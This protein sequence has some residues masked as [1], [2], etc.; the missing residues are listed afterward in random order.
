MS[1]DGQLMPVD[2]FAPVNLSRAKTST[3]LDGVSLRRADELRELLTSAAHAYYVMDTP[4]LSDGVY[5]AYFRD[6]QALEERFP[7]LKYPDSPTQKVMGAVGEGFQEV[8]HTVP[9]LS[10]YTETDHTPAGAMEFHRRITKALGL[11]EEDPVEYVAEMKFDGLAISLRYEHGRL[12]RAVTRGDGESGEDV[13]Q[14]VMTIKDIPKH[15][16][17]VMGRQFPVLEVRGEIFMKKA[18][19]AAINE[20]LDSVGEKRL[21][22]PRNAAAGALRQH[23]PKVTAQRPLSFFAYGIGEV[24]G[25]TGQP[26]Y[27]QMMLVLS[28]LGFPVNELSMMPIPSSGLL[29]AYNHIQ[30]HREGLPYEIDGVV[31][32]VN[33]RALQEKLGFVSREPRWACAHK[34]P[35]EEA[36]TK[37]TTIEVQVGR[38]GV[39]TPVAVLEPIFVGGTTVTYATLHNETEIRRKDIRIGDDVIVRRAGDVV[40]EI[41]GPVIFARDKYAATSLQ[42]DLFTYVNGV[43]PSCKGPILR[44]DGAVAYRCTSGLACPAQREQGILHFAGRRMMDIQGLGDK[45]VEDLVKTGLVERPSDL[46][47]LQLTDLL[48]LETVGMGKTGLNLLKAIDDSKDTTLA[49]FIYAL[50]IR[51]VG[52]STAK[53]LAQHFGTFDKLAMASID[54]LLEVRDVGPIV[55]ESIFAYFAREDNLEEVRSLRSSGIAWNDLVGTASTDHRPLL[56]CAIVVTGTLPSL[57]REAAIEMLEKLGGRSTSS[58]SNKTAFVLAGKDASAGKLEKAN[59]HS[60]PIVDET[61]LK[62]MLD[63]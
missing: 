54:Q 45:I 7:E 25:W 33:D 30:E 5:D 61:W 12:V 23:D 35:A 9:M 17:G 49:R 56:G 59:K 24:E 11:K 14:N 57:T 1:S 15:L 20:H 21:V 62:G 2:R 47:K 53:D 3:K 38:T 63:A 52:E 39:L 27:S 8:K 44:E 34:F 16:K 37:L 31:Y 18:D 46:Y 51:Q 36:V 32:K 55:A 13:T 58:V 22:N 43:C 60:V 26:T 41:V 28:N 40:P 48:P 10:L 6:L 29:I 50:G 19:F 4:F 42:W